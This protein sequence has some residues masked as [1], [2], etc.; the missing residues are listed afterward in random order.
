M[1]RASLHWA[2]LASALAMGMT[3][4]ARAQGTPT[5]NP[6]PNSNEVNLVGTPAGGPTVTGGFTLTT[7][8]TT[9]AIEINPNTAAGGT[10]FSILDALYGKGDYVQIATPTNTLNL[11]GINTLA[12][13]KYAANTNTLGYYANGTGA[14]H[15]IVTVSQFGFLTGQSTILVTPG[16]TGSPF[17]WALSTV[18]VGTAIY[19]QN[20][21]STGTGVTNGTVERLAEFSI[22][23]GANA[24]ATVLA[25]EDGTDFDYNDLVVQVTTVSS[26]VPEPSTLAIAGLGALGMI[27]YGLR[28]RKAMGA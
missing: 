8:S 1:R 14:F 18:G 22:T 6:T 28:R 26:V 12:Q 15:S 2:F 13:V 21:H 24:G 5:I 10:G 20:L 19:S 9:S 3:V 17:E 7:S 11:N 23:G 16:Q 4:S 25:W 27:G